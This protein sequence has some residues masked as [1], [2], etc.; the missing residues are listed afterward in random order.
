M[1]LGHNILNTINFFRS[2]PMP[3]ILKKN[4]SNPTIKCNFFIF[5]VKILNFKYIKVKNLYII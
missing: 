4:G 1:E 5:I 2:L 3:Y